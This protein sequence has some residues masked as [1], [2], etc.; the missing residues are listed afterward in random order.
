MQ[1]LTLLIKMVKNKNVFIIVKNKNA[2]NYADNHLY[3]IKKV[4][5][6]QVTIAHIKINNA[7][8]LELHLNVVC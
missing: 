7:N 1:L 6:H 3:Q 2:V 8:L 4:V 5:I